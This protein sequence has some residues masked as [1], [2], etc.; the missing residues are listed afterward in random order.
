MKIVYLAPIAFSELKQRPQYLVEGLS[1]D[2]EVYYIEPT[3]RIAAC[4]MYGYSCKSDC[5]KVNRNLTVFRCDGKVVLPYRWNIYDIFNLNGVYEYVQLKELLNSADVIIVAYEGWYNVVD[6]VKNKIL[7]YDKM[8]ENTFLTK[9][10]SNK[11]FMKKCE[12]ALLKK[13]ACALVSA[14][15][16]AK[17]FDGKLPAYLVPNA[18]DGTNTCY[19]EY[20]DPED[21]KRVYGYIGTIAGWFDND[22]IQAIADDEKN[23][24]ILVGPCTTK[25]IEK[26]NVVYVGKVEKDR[27]MEHI[28]EF[29]VCL[30]PFKR[31][32]LLE[33]INPVK[34]YEYLAFNKPIIAVRSEETEKFEANIYLYT[35]VEQ[36]KSICEQELLPPFDSFEEYKTFLKDNSWE[37]R[38]K[39]VNEILERLIK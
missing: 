37:S 11:A 25:K 34:I 1:V 21:K 28:K 29:D 32:E 24:V 9:G 30:Y 26:E 19:L 10:W 38:V 3:K 7:V 14:S 22:V 18:F 27:A 6:K 17:K 36:V 16:F 5:Y 39:Q 2:N 15:S 35:S 33:T 12:N 23:T 4:F 13:C 8:D 31:D 20:E